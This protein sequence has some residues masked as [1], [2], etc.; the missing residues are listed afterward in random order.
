M[1]L[2]P[3]TFETGAWVAVGV[4]AA[5][6]VCGGAAEIGGAC[7]VE[8]PLATLP[9]PQPPSEAASARARTSAGPGR[10]KLHDE[11]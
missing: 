1:A 3:G 10:E 2:A 9:P 7:P 4:A 8:G 5:R 11:I 6:G